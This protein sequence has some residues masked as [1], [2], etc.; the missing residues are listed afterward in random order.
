[1]TTIHLPAPP[2]EDAHEAVGLS[3]AEASRRLAQFG[4]NALQTV[5]TR[6]A[7][8]DVFG[9]LVDATIIV[10]M[11]LLSVALNVV[12]SSRS[13]RRLSACDEA[14]RRRRQS[15]ATV[16]GASR[17]AVSS[18]PLRFV[19]LVTVGYLTCVELVKRPLMAR[20]LS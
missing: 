4:S 9:A 17:P 12:Q 1:M 18:F 6:S 8:R 13:R 20:V 10:I 3:S 7:A 19:V 11:V 14:S 5:P 16:S 15:F 2:A